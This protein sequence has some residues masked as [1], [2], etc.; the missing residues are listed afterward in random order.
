MAEVAE[1]FT[2]EGDVDAQVRG[3]QLRAKV[4]ARRGRFEEA[5]AASEEAAALAA[6]TDYLEL[7]S[8][9]LMGQIEVLTLAGRTADAASAIRDA[10]EL[11][12]RK[13]NV[14]EEARAM[15]LLEDLE[16]VDPS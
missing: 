15:A 14:V 5:L 2:I 12:R 4:L 10:V 9:A 7:H 8:H 6:G 1:R 16:L 13:G 3:T 11:L